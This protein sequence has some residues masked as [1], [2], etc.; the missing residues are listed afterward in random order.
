MR[1][2][3]YRFVRVSADNVDNVLPDLDRGVCKVD[4]L[5]VADDSP[6][7]RRCTTQE[8]LE[9]TLW[10][11]EL[12][13]HGAVVSGWV[14]FGEVVG[15]V[16]FTGAPV[17]TKLL[18]K[19]PVAEPVEAHVHCLCAFWLYLVVYDFLGCRVVSLDGGW[20]LLVP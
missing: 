3:F 10:C 16:E 14:V 7:G 20:W 17:K 12:F 13:S 2:Y 18:L 1:C 8:I 6:C 9:D 19:F 4:C 5:F 11:E 15:V